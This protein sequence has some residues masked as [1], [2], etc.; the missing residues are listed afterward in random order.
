VQL[1]ALNPEIRT[2]DIDLEPGALVSVGH[3]YKIENDDT[4]LVR[5]CSHISKGD[6]AFVSTWNPCWYI[7]TEA[8]W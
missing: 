8:V 7:N 1:W 5:P 4:V 3:I 6:L 2:P